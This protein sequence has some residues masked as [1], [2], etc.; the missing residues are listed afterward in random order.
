VR[1]AGAERIAVVRAIAGSPD[2][3]AA[4]EGLRAA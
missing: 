4:A 2:H 1:A 3:Q